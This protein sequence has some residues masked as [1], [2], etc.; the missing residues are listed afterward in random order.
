MHTFQSF[1]TGAMKSKWENIVEYNLAESAVHPLC[2][3]D[4]VDQGTF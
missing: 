2:V 4:L 3:R 1:E